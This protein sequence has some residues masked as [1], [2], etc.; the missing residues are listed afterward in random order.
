MR[1]RIFAGL[2]AHRFVHLA[3]TQAFKRRRLQ[4][5]SA[6]AQTRHHRARARKQEVAGQNCDRVS[7]HGVRRRSSS[8]HGGLVHNVVVVERSKVRELDG[9][10]RERDVSVESITELCGKDGERRAHALSARIQQVTAR[11]IGNII[12]ESDVLGDF[13]FDHRN[14]SLNGRSQPLQCGHGGQPITQTES[15]Y[16]GHGVKPRAASLRGASQRCPL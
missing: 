11:R 4:G 14:A 10:G 8:A 3:D 2:R 13:G 1:D 5:H 9:C 15:R 6:F 7:P 12:G 16:R